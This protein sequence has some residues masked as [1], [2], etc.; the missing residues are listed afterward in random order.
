MRIS[1]PP[2][3]GLPKL[4][5]RSTVWLLLLYFLIPPIA[6]CIPSKPTLESSTRTMACGL[7]LWAKMEGMHR[8]HSSP[9]RSHVATSAHGRPRPP[10]RLLPTAQ[11]ALLAA[12]WEPNDSDAEVA[13]VVVVTAPAAM[14]GAVPEVEVVVVEEAPHGGTAPAEAMAYGVT[15]VSTLQ[16]VVWSMRAAYNRPAVQEVSK[17]VTAGHELRRAAVS[18]SW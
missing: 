16:P 9:G 2:S 10:R 18:A 6:I 12:G 13:S 7:R 17:R 1:L 11:W 8:R 5:L 4:W 15:A 14:V 3:L